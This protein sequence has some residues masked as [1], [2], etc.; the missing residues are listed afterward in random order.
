[1]TILGLSRFQFAM[2]TVFH[3][4]FVP[5]SIGLAFTVA[6]M[7]TMYV[8]KR[9][10]VYRRMAQFWGKIFLLSF[11]VGV[12]TGIIQEFQFGMNWSNYSRFMGD[13]FGAPLAIEALLAFFME[14]TFIG[15][16]M[17]TWNRF[18]PGVHV[19]FI[20]LTWL[21]STISAIWIL[22][23]N[24]FMQH[25]VGFEIGRDGRAKMTDFAAIVSNPQL[26][27][28]FPHV[29]T[30]ALM[31]GSFVV[32]GMSAFGL[33]RK[34]ADRVFFTR[35]IRVAAVIALISAILVIIA[36][37][38]QTSFI[39]HD[40]PMKFAATEGLYD[41][42]TGKSAPWTVIALINE[43]A[44]TTKGIEI[45]AMLSLLAYHKLTGSVMGMNEANTQLMNAYHDKFPGIANF[46]V[47]TNVLFW[48]FR[49]MAAVGF[50]VLL[51]SAFVLWFTR[52]SKNTLADSRWKLWILGICTYLPFIGTTGGWLIT[53][54]G[55]YPWIVYGLQTIADAVSPTATVPSLLFTNIV[56]FLLFLL[57]GGVMIFY[58]RRVLHQGPE[59]DPDAVAKQSE[60]QTA[61]AVA[62]TAARKVALA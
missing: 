33:M 54:L 45:P 9:K 49:F 12:V 6:V 1:M 4:F 34:N 47:P 26:W 38:A 59:P 18:K 57:M 42:T 35:S 19:I 28:S 21:G 20:W 37:D 43:Q 15:V 5:L 36:G 14:S 29:A 44:K 58:S 55:R 51:L 30:A 16:W 2:T 17:F 27:V 50:G 31:T 13:I 62:N 53:E 48:S 39:I 24:S 61:P 32:V 23:A 10:Y 46:Y 8:V 25:P 40:Q 11:A 41:T 60:S 7:E 56:Y 52:K 22:A 3:F